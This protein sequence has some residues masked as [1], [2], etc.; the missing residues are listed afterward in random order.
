MKKNVK[1]IITTMLVTC[2]T[3]TFVGCA[4]KNDN[5]VNNEVKTIESKELKENIG[6]EDW[7]VVDT[8][9][10]DAYNG[11]KLDGVSRGGHIKGATDFSASW[12][13]VDKKDKDETLD[14]ALETKGIS[15]EKN[16]VLYDTDGKDVKE[17]ADYL[18]KK[19]YEKIYTYDIDDWAND[20][21]NPMESYQN[22]EMLVPPSWVKDLIDGKKPETYSGG[23]YKIFEVSWGKESDSPS[24]LKRGHIPGAIHINTDDVEKGPLWN[25]ISDEELEK[26]ALENG[27]TKDTTTVLYGDDSMAAFRVAT[28]LKYMGVENVKV[29]NGG[30]DK[31][32]NAGYDLEKTSNL[33]VAVEEFGDKIPA[34]KDYI[35]GLD[36]A[37]E[38]I[39]DKEN[40]N[41]VDIRSWEEFI[42]KTSGYD[43]IKP[44]GRPDGAVWGHAG[45]DAQSLQDYRNIDGTMINKDEIIKMWSEWGITPNQNLAFYC[46]TGWRAA[47]VLYYADVMGLKNI[48]LYDGGWNEWSGN[49]GNEPNPIVTGEP[50]KK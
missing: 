35:I 9:E 19:G 22:Y 24:Y 38:L 5:V 13:S 41:L 49:T 3:F 15:K 21:N 12:L 17:V 11:W 30:L 1:L 16:V 37:K 20:V 4:N 40:S 6:K 31:W 2:A 25:I 28:T 29:L 33:K 14:K 50:A 39:K 48:A 47:E 7:V 23:D 42:G 18:A 36:G 8:R 45:S 44:K 43:Y 46:G 26:F 32:V 27:I 10:N 34:N